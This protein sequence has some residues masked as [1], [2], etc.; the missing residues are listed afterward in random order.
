MKS[1]ISIIICIVIYM[2]LTSSILNSSDKSEIV[3]QATGTNTSSALLK[4]SA[5]IISQRLKLYGLNSFEVNVL[6]DKRQIEIQLPDNADKSE[7][8]GLVSA[9][10]EIAFYETYTHNEIE[11]L[12]KPGN[13]LFNLLGND[14]IKSGSDPRVGCLVKESREKT[15]QYLRSSAPVRDCKFVWGAESKKSGSCLFALKT[16]DGKPLIDRSDIDSVRIVTG[17]DPQDYKIQIKLKSEASAVFAEAT[18]RNLDRSIAIVI[19]NEVYS[20]PVVRNVIEGGS[21]EV[22]GDFTLREVNCFPALFN[23]NQLPVDFKV[24]R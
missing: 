22:T 11:V 7:I 4:Q 16:S 18:K 21:I 1:L 13:R 9:K 5:D 20:W 10:G 15:D 17:K 12:L 24:I 2:T 8:E 3:L 19:D 6:P 14:Q 23:S